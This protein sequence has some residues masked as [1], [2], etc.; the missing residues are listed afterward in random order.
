MTDAGVG[1]R[2]IPSAQ[3]HGERSRRT[4]ADTLLND[5]YRGLFLADVPLLDVRAP[6]EF[7]QGAFPNARNLPL[8]DDAERHEVGLVYKR[9]GPAAAIALGQTLVGGATRETRLQAWLDWCD[10]H[11]EGQLYC[12]RGGMRSMTVQQWLAEAGRPIPRIHGGYKTMRRFLLESL[13]ENAAAL[14]LILLSGRSGTGKTRVIA[15]LAQAV[16][17]EDLARHR[18]SAFGRRPGGQPSQIDFE[19]ALA[20]RLLRLQERQQR[21]GPLP[22]VVEDESKLVG[23]RLIP[24]VLYLQMQAAPRVLIEEPMEERV[25]VGLEDYVQQPLAEYARSHG[26]H[27]ALPRLGSEL[28]ASLDRIRNRLGDARHRELRQSLTRALEIQ[29]HSGD[30]DAHRGW[31][32][33]LLSG[34]YDPLYD[35]ALRARGSVANTLFAGTRSQ[36]TAFLQDLVSRP[37]FAGSRH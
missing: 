22:V 13:E 12:F 24:P 15:G 33:E 11:P 37:R 7:A 5:D 2:D 25:Q 18:G 36:V 1:P 14:P 23:H 26:E 30:L 8:L 20:I 31:I 17:L 4:M 10:Q 16:D 21:Y 35:H 6:C 34:Y 27:D 9:S 29:A 28:L 19:N 32:R 3:P